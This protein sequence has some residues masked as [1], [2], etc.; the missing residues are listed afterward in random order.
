MEIHEQK[1]ESPGPWGPPDMSIGSVALFA[2]ATLTISYAGYNVWNWWAATHAPRAASGAPATSAASG[3]TK[4]TRATG[5]A[6]PNGQ[7]S[8]S[9]P[10]TPGA[11]V[12][13]CVVNGATTYVSSEA[14]CSA[15]AKV[16][17]IRID[18]KEN[19]SDGLPN[20]EQIIRRPSPAAQAYVA[21]AVEDQNVERRALCQAYDEEVKSID[22]RAR[23]PLS[24]QEQD[25]LTA[26]RRKARDEQFR[27]HC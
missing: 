5:S 2:L 23:Q 6:D 4:Q 25:R 17:V 14:D 24:G 3:L 20:A 21:P 13:K 10:G 26:K 15:P 19:I 27:L 12:I 7:P 18:P 8:H 11:V 16:T 1:R 22:E 9:A